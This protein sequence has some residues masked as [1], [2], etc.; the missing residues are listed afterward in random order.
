MIFSGGLR[1]TQ[2]D[3]VYAHITGYLYGAVIQP[4]AIALGNDPF[5]S[6]VSIKYFLWLKHLRMNKSFYIINMK[7]GN[8]KQV[9]PLGAGLALR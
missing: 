7:R 5:A 6:V 4:C 3:T 2:S 9:V 1:V 8:G